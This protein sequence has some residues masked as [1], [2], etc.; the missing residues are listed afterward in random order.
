MPELLY[1]ETRWGALVSYGLAAR[2]LGDV[3]PMARPVSPE[4]RCRNL[5]AKSADLKTV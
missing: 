3:L 2:M 1:L 4:R 5:R